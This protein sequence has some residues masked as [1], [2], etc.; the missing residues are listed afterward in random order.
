MRSRLHSYE[1]MTEPILELDGVTKQYGAL[2][3]L[4]IEHLVVAAGE[5]I[6]LLG[7]DQP[8]AEVLINLI[9]GAS[10]P[11]TGQVRVFG[12]S[13][14]EIVDSAD[15]LTLLDRFGIVSER[16]ALLEPL[17]VIQNLAI[18]FG[19]EIEP[20]PPA[21][22]RQASDLASEVGVTEASWE[23]RVGDL[24]AAL[25]MRVRL[26]RALALGPGLLLVEHPT[27]TLPPH[28][29][30]P[31]G[32]KLRAVAEARAAAVLSMTADPAYAAS[33][34]S[35]ALRVEPATGRLRSKI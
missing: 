27:V 25:R 32:R 19:L 31:F 23:R 10:L 14:S 35:R 22:V 13:T 18:P 24:D 3:P 15:W 11:D 16:A 26:A 7:F 28:E 12:R 30:A 6:A 4:R 1:R 29:V 33:A 21:I 5:Q 8:A 34:S 2:R 17:T 9:T 20:P